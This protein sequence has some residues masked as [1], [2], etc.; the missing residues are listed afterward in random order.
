MPVIDSATVEAHRLKI[1]LAAACEALAQARE[2]LV[3]FERRTEDPRTREKMASA[4]ERKRIEFAEL[5]DKLRQP[6]AG[7]GDRP[8]AAEGRPP[9]A[10]AAAREAMASIFQTRGKEGSP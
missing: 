6:W 8:G 3:R 7:A 1:R 4:L 10:N 2:G 5:R 9:G